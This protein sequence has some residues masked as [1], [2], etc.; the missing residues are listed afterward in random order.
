MKEHIN[1]D[2]NLFFITARLKL[3][4]DAL[5]LTLDESLFN[6]LYKHDIFLFDNLLTVFY[7]RLTNSRQL[8]KLNDYLFEL[9]RAQVS[10]V[11]ILN[12]ILY[13]D[14]AF[15]HSFLS[16]TDTFKAIA[17]RQKLAYLEV[18][19]LLTAKDKQAAGNDVISEEEYNILF[20]SDE[21]GD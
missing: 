17:G 7:Q 10:L 12:F 16:E 14:T 6:E 5:H 9:C 3:L 20:S 13:Q 21:A 1:Y 18:R 11:N 8:L 2:D 15:N 19:E 4:E